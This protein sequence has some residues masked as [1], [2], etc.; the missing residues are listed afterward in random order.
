MLNHIFEVPSTETI[1]AGFPS[2]PSKG[3]TEGHWT[4]E[5]W[6]HMISSNFSGSGGVFKFQ[7]DGVWFLA[8]EF[9]NKRSTPQLEGKIDVNGLI[10]CP[11][12]NQFY[13]L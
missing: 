8:S 2:F 6:K 10:L 13:A 3:E 5:W 1:H 12:D 7:A 9:V 4:G 11:F